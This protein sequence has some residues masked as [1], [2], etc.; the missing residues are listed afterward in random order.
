MFL[1][2]LP[3]VLQDFF[4]RKLSPK[5]SSKT[6]SRPRA[7]TIAADFAYRLHGNEALASWTHCMSRGEPRARNL[8]KF[9]YKEPFW[10]NCFLAS[11]VSENVINITFTL[12]DT[13][14]IRWVWG[15]FFL[16]NRIV[17]PVKL[18][19]IYQWYPRLILLSIWFPIGAYWYG[20][21]YE[22]EYNMRI[23]LRSLTSSTMYTQASTLSCLVP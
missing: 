1:E 13:S 16:F 8:S 7:S 12:K 21:P 11:W 17:Q 20:S 18:Q 23:S 15:D 6:W 22:D 5:C 19:R 9:D 14:V 10:S 2:I 4:A 3:A